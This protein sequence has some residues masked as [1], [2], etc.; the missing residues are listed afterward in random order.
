MYLLGSD[1]CPAS[2]CLADASPGERDEGRVGRCPT[3]NQPRTREWTLDW[4]GAGRAVFS[5]RA[6]LD[7]K[8]ES[9]FMYQRE[10]VDRTH[11]LLC[12]RP[13]WDRWK[14]TGLR[15]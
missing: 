12:G 3:G 13:V 1:P 5:T 10:W 11:I 14:Y 4:G 6:R 2:L 8:S 7:L 15:C 9:V